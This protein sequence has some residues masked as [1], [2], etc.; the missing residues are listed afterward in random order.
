M[1]LQQAIDELTSTYQSLDSVAQ[2]LLV[3][4]KEVDDA[5]KAA[6]PDTAEFIA[7]TVLQKYNPY[8]PKQEKKIVKNADTVE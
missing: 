1:S 2:G 4:P 6:Q 8:T 5:L 3:D 7:L